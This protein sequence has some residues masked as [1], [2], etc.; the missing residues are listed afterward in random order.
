[1]EQLHTKKAPIRHTCEKS[2]DP[3]EK[4]EEDNDKNDNSWDDEG[5]GKTVIMC[6]VIAQRID[7]QRTF[8]W[9]TQR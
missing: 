4:H 2:K 5:K 7:L 8:T 1:M 6:Y 9:S 3:V